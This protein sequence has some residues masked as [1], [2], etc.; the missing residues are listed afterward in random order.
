MSDYK[1]VYFDGQGRG[2]I[3]RL[4]FA[5]AEVVYED[6]R[7]P[8]DKWPQLKACEYTSPHH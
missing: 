2:E 6:D 4:I 7:I 1:L 8:M 5:A 3:I